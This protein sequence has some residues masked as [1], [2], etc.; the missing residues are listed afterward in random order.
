MQDMN[1]QRVLLGLMLAFLATS[2]AALSQYGYSGSVA[3]PALG[4]RISDLA[5]PELERTGLDYGVRVVDLAPG[6]PARTAGLRPGDI[7]IGFDGRPVYSVA[8]LAWLLKDSPA[9][10]SVEVEY[11]RNG[12]RASVDVQLFPGSGG[13]SPIQPI[14]GAYLGVQPQPLTDD[15]REAFK[16][17]QDQ[18]VL[19]ATVMQA[20]PAE[21]AGLRAGDVIVRMDRRAIRGIRDVHRTLAYFEPGEQVQVEYI[22]DGRPSVVTVALGERPPQTSNSPVWTP[23]WNDPEVLQRLVPPREYWKRLMNDVLDSLDRSWSEWYGR[24]PQG[25]PETL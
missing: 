18:G 9:G 4:M 2:S 8:R 21:R 7:V 20:S 11:V 17:P 3:G 23:G 19:V 13:V 5:F 12:E 25:P 16:V 22:R 10:A 6:G 14:S 15:L 24:T 1:A